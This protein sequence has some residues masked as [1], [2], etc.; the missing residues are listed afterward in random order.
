MLEIVIK[1]G[2]LSEIALKQH[3]FHHLKHHKNQ[4][5]A[6]AGFF[7][8]IFTNRNT[9]ALRPTPLFSHQTNKRKMKVF[10]DMH[11]TALR[12][13][14]PPFSRRKMTIF[15]PLSS[16]YKL[17]KDETDVELVSLLA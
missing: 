7:I 17:M 8:S 3:N 4:G 11:S 5:P 9:A 16:A 12:R 1:V 6:I 10:K 13:I 2:K 15:S 14:N